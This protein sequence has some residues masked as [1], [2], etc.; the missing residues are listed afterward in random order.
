L[1]WPPPLPSVLQVTSLVVFD[2]NLLPVNCVSPMSPLDRLL[3]RIGMIS[4]LLVAPVMIHIVATMVLNRGTFFRKMSNLVGTIGTISAALIVTIVSSIVYPF[5]CQEHPS[6]IPTMRAED[7][8]VCFSSQYR[9]LHRSMIAASCA[10]SL[11]PLGFFAW[12]TVVVRL[13]PKKISAGD[14]EFLH[15][16]CFVFSRFALKY[17]WFILVHWARNLA[18]ALVPVLPGS[19]VQWSSFIVITNVSV[20]VTTRLLPWRT[21]ESNS[22]EILVS[23]SS[24]RARRAGFP[25]SGPGAR[26]GGRG[27]LPPGRTGPL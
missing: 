22:F 21:D 23:S 18:V 7:G 19:A 11:L 20:I 25:A 8:V 5:Q 3:A 6:G 17:H 27:F 26:P 24:S 12:I 9:S 16:Y 4:F 15:T 10:A 2:I 14:A 13:L 1:Q